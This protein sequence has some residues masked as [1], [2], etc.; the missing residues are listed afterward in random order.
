MKSVIA[1]VFSLM[2]VLSISLMACG[3]AC[4]QQPAPVGKPPS[5]TVS[6]LRNPVDKS[7][8][9]MLKG[10]DLFEKMHAMAPAATLRYKLLPRQ[11]DTDM[12]GITL[13]IVGDTMSIPVAVAPDNTFTLERNSKAIAEDAAVMPNRRADSMTWRTEIRTPGLPSDTRRLGDLRLECQ[14]GMEAGLVSNDSPLIGA[15]VNLIQGALDYCNAAD[16][17]YLFFSDRPLFGVTM[18]SGERTVVLSVDQLYAGISRIPMSAS[19]L[20]Y[21]DCQVLLD[22]TYFLPLGDKSWPDD[23]LVQLEYMDDTVNGM[24]EERTP[25]PDPLPGKG[26]L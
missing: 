16:P 13:K 11:P 24:R 17:Q 2:T 15:L 12:Q 4:A 25:A 3:T 5:V 23:T 8:R 6:G 19:E 10:M 18:K 1:P 9:K 21:C 26:A 20:K 22:R 14:V 7:Y